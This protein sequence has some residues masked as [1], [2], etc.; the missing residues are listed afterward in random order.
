MI[1]AVIATVMLV[2]D[3]TATHA[4]SSQMMDDVARKKKFGQYQ[5]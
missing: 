2:T 4:Y 5:I 3:A 1:L